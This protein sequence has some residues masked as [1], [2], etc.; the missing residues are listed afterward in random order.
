MTT[1]PTALDQ[2]EQQLQEACDKAFALAKERPTGANR[3]AYRQAEKA[4]QDFQRARVEDDGEPIY[5]NI[6]ELVDALDAE[7]WKISRSTA[8]EHREA[9][10]LRLRSDGTIT[11]T[12][13]LEYARTHLDRKDGTPGNQ[14][15]SPQ[16]EKT[17]AEIRRIQ[18][19]ANMRELKYR[20]SLGELI[21]RNQVEIEL[22]SRATDL[23]SYLEAIARSSAGRIIKIAKGDPQQAPELVCYLLGL[24]RKALDNYSRPI[25]GFEEEEEESP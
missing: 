4:L 11:E 22:S 9:G 1:L 10:K 12:I 5:R 20:E 7:G 18:A 15:E 2:Q 25:K 3:K 16:A 19:D 17:R 14:V 21:P 13:A 8:Y 6:P 24:Y 23:R